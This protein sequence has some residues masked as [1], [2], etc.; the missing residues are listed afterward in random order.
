LAPDKTSIREALGRALFGA[1]RYAEAAAEF[2]AV[3]ERALGTLAAAGCVLV[4]VDLAELSSLSKAAGA[5]SYYEQSRDLDA[6]L[7]AAGSALSTREVAAA[8]ASPDVH[9]IY[10]TDVLGGTAITFEDYRQAMEVHRPRLQAAYARHF[11]ALQLAALALPTTALPAR[12]I[13]EDQAVELNGRRVPTFATFLRNTRVMTIAGIPGLS[14]PAGLT[15]AGLPVGLEFDG[16]L[17]SDRAL[18]ALGVAVE[19]VLGRLAPPQWAPIEP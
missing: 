3:I 15:A 18:L 4:P 7:H 19:G 17:G 14:V 1:Q 16:P 2:E 9:E 8:I 13:G 6:Y 11:E 5:I 12:P 10:A